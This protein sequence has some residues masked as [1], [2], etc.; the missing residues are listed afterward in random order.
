MA[1]VYFGNFA[2]SRGESTGIYAFTPGR[3]FTDSQTLASAAWK[4][5]WNS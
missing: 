3:P 5:I 1:A 2:A 4:S